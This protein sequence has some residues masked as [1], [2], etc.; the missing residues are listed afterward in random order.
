MENYTHSGYY[1]IFR[2]PYS[3][4][5]ATQRSSIYCVSDK[6]NSVLVIIPLVPAFYS[7][8]INIVKNHIARKIY[9]IASDIGIG[10]VSDYYMSWDTITNTFRKSCKIFSKFMVENYTRNDFVS[11]I[12]RVENDNLTLDVPR[13]EKDI[14]TISIS[15][16]KDYVHSSAPYSCDVILDDSYKKRLFVGE[17]NLQ[18]A[19]YI[20]KNLDVYDEIHM[21]YITGNYSGMTYNELIKEYP[22]L[23][24]KIYCNQFASNEEFAFAKSKGILIG[25][26]YRDSI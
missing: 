25:G 18:K 11:D 2:P 21:P 13:S 10:F 14:S 3:V 1:N 8:V 4:N 20:N 17:M 15:L 19:D 23:I 6:Y 7:D 16:T 24:K 22:A 5:N 26:R 12:I 9:L